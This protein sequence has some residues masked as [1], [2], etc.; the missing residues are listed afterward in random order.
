MAQSLCV[1]CLKS[2]HTADLCRNPRSCSVCRGDHNTLLHGVSQQKTSPAVVSGTVNTISELTPVNSLKQ[3][4]LLMTCQAL[5]V[6]PKGKSMPVRILLDSGADVSCVTTQVAKHLKLMPV[7]PVAVRPCGPGDQYICQSADFT[8]STISDQ[9]WK[10]DM[11][12]VII[13]RITGIQPRQDAS[14]V[15]EMA[16]KQGWALA[17]PK[18]DQ[19]GWIDVLLGADV[20]PHVQLHEGP[21]SSIMAVPTVFGQALMG[22][23]PTQGPLEWAQASIHTLAQTDVLP[24]TDENLNTTLLRFWE[25]ENPLQPRLA[26][27]PEEIRVQ[28][29]YASKHVFVQSAGK[30]QVTLPKKLNW[31]KAEGQHSGG[32]SQMKGLS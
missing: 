24:P 22:T 32:S 20:L 4:K 25:L 1:K 11:S 10:L 14:V 26:F 29:E 7:E 2:G 17:D 9:S 15:R 27:S 6:G 23:Y 28:L 3:S 21:I 5:I 18:F 13:D 30:Y 31:E 19:P 12:A 8:I 16:V